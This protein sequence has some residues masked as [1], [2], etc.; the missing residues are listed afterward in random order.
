MI[1]TSASIGNGSSFPISI[2]GSPRVERCHTDSTPSGTGK[3]FESGFSDVILLVDSLLSDGESSG[4]LQGEFAERWVQRSAELIYWFSTGTVF[5]N[6]DQIS[7][8]GAPTM[9]HTYR[10]L[11]FHRNRWQRYRVYLE[12]KLSVRFSGV[13][14]ATDGNLVGQRAGRR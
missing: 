2:N 8:R 1:T 11:L 12:R 7:I 13:S 4:G 5:C 14:Q 3:G 10:F 9:S 6:M